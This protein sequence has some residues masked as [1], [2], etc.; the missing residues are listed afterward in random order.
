MKKPD[1]LRVAKA[2]E[3]AGPVGTLLVSLVSSPRAS[4]SSAWA[5]ARISESLRSTNSTRC[6]LRITSVRLRRTTRRVARCEGAGNLSTAFL[7][8]GGALVAS[9]ELLWFFA[10]LA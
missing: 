3:P 2:A 7:I 8:A 10:P 6:A 4:G 5:W 1:G 9:G